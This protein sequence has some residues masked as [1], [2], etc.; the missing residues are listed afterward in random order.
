MNCQVDEVFPAET[1]CRTR[2]WMGGT[3]LPQVDGYEIKSILGQGAMVVVFMAL[4]KSL[5]RFVALK[6]LLVGRFASDFA[7]T[8]FRREARAIAALRHPNIVHLETGCIDVTST[9][10]A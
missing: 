8:R 2:A 3:A 7:L 10:V 5:E 9:G 6:M 1:E 4:D